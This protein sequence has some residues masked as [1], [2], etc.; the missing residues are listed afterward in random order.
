MNA[1]ERFCPNCGTP[2]SVVPQAGMGMGVGA[3]MQAPPKKKFPILTV[4]LLAVILVVV[5]LGG[6]F[7]KNTVMTPAYEKPIKKL[8]TSIEK[9]D[10][11]GIIDVLPNGIT[12]MIEM[13]GETTESFEEEMDEFADEM[14]DMYGDDLKIDYKIKETERLT[15]AEIDE[16]EDNYL[17]LVDISEGKRV[18]MYMTI[19]ADGEVEREEAELCVIKSE[20]KWCIDLSSIY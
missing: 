16:I 1:G 6:V 7:L 13:V 11:K 14:K 5:I 9:G 20:G 12:D 8:I 17:G 2:A 19:K 4:S 10:A 18:Y 3:G 15:K